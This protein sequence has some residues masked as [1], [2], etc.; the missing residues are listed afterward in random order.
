MAWRQPGRLDCLWEKNPSLRL[1]RRVL[2]HAGAAHVVDQE[3]YPSL[4]PSVPPLCR[5]AIGTNA[6]QRNATQRNAT[7][8][9]HLILTQPSPTQPALSQFEARKARAATRSASSLVS[10]LLESR[11]VGA[12]LEIQRSSSRQTQDRSR[13]GRQ[14]T[15]SQSVHGTGQ[16]HDFC[17]RDSP[18][19]C[20]LVRA[21]L[22]AC[23]LCLPAWPARP[24]PP[25]SAIH[26]R[27]RSISS[28][29]AYAPQPCPDPASHFLHATRRA[30]PRHLPAYLS[31]APRYTQSHSPTVH[32]QPPRGLPL[33]CPLLPSLD[34]SSCPRLTTFSYLPAQQST[35]SLHN[36]AKPALADTS[37]AAAL[38]LT[39]PIL[40]EKDTR[41]YKQRQ[42]DKNRAQR[43]RAA[44]A[45][46]CIAFLSRPAPGGALD[47]AT[48]H[49]RWLSITPDP[50][51][52]TC[53]CIL[54]CACSL[55]RPSSVCL[56]AIL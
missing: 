28:S 24:H 3:T 27:T 22:P 26:T 42:R 50:Q 46:P 47:P 39:G 8:P 6:T 37:T 17:L 38:E 23:L 54:A 13:P 9:P 11:Q 20:L 12:S 19:P 51:L 15:S 36:P 33:S 18:G 52:P 29:C 55:L 5:R 56:P 34:P 53:V 10:V 30:A 31:R 14:T 44:A 45:A 43:D 49:L 41:A 4:P 1:S 21:C 48:A 35:Y 2:V 7:Q 40:A 16:T 32:G 25:H